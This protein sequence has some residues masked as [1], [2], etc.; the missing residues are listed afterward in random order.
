MHLE[1]IL[2]YNFSRNIISREGLL[3]ISGMTSQ[4]RKPV[5]FPLD[6]RL[7]ISLPFNFY[8]GFDLGQ[9]LGIYAVTDIDLDIQLSMESEQG[10]L[11][12]SRVSI[13]GD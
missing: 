6:Y 11:S 1:S 12:L 9:L 5:I 10:S 2:C 3:L 7:S 4:D 8:S 13:Q